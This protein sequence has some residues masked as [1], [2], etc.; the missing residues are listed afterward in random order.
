VQARITL[1]VVAEDVVLGPPKTAFSSSSRFARTNASTET[2]A[3]SEDAEGARARTFSDRQQN[4]NPKTTGEKEGGRD[5]TALRQPRGP[6]QTEEQKDSNDR[7]AKYGRRDREREQDAERRNGDKQDSRWGQREDR[8]QRDERRQNGERQG[9]W[10]DRE[11][12]RQNNRGWDREQAEK[13]PEWFDEP[14]KKQEE[15]LGVGTAHTQA[16]FQKWKEMMKGGNKAPAEEVAP[17][18]PPPPPVQ[19]TTAKQVASMKLDN[20]SEPMFGGLGSK[21]T[22]A[23]LE[24]IVPTAKAAATPSKTKSSRFASVFKKDEAP[25]A[26]VQEASV[27]QQ[28]MLEMGQGLNED[29]A[30]FQRILQ[31]LGGANIGSSQESAAATGGPSEPASPQ[32][33]GP[34]AGAKQKSRFFDS[35]PK[36]PD[37]NSP[38]S[39]FQSPRVQPGN[40]LPPVRNMVDDPNGFFG[41]PMSQKAP[42]DSSALPF[43]PS[44]VVSPE[45]SQSSN[46]H[47]DSYPLQ[48]RPSEPIVSAPPSRGPPSR[49]PATPDVGIQN[50]LAAQRAQR[51]HASN[52]D[53][54]FLLGLLQGPPQQARPHQDFWIGQPPEPHAPKPRAPPPPGLIDDQLLRNAP[55]E[56]SR[57]EHSSMPGQ[58]LSRRSSQRAPTGAPP[59]FDEHAMFMQQQMQQRRNFAEGPQQPQQPLSNRRMGGHPSMSGMIPQQQQQ[60]QFPP[61][62]PFMQSPPI[63]HQGPPQGGPP[64]GFAPNMRHPQGF[65]NVPNIFQAQQQREPPGFAGMMQNPM[66]PPVPPPGFGAPMPPGLMGMRSP[67]DGLPSGA[68]FRGA[69]RGFENFDGQ[70]R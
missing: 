21:A 20:F 14:M 45:P 52:K 44:N 22:D 48:Q 65:A 9:G 15:D 58:D 68:G 1:T 26:P 19:S 27:Q 42:Q 38:Q 32:V 67:P 50:L 66:S 16:D 17:T 25:P 62:F 28:P 24:S 53:S 33:R 56:M 29:R 13:E 54:E 34:V 2:T 12:N 11:S 64:P 18:P 55:P 6:D 49:G 69:G 8:G 3:G 51:P 5:W 10:R 60:P 47:R 30:G 35:V 43:P 39:R 59:G 41:L 36:S 40:N 70:R 7:L 63:Q 4:R 46:G 61:D 31:M 23:P 37:V 57:P